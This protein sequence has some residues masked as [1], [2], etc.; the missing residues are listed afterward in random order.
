CGQGIP[1]GQIRDHDFNSI[2]PWLAHQSLFLWSIKTM[3]CL[4]LLIFGDR[5]RPGGSCDAD[6]IKFILRLALTFRSTPRRYQWR[7]GRS[8]SDRFTWISTTSFEPGVSPRWSEYQRR[9]GTDRQ[10]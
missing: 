2:D 5:F 7:S 1:T 3:P 10:R 9:P 6:A 8:S 4:F